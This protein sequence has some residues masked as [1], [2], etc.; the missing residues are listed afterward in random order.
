MGNRRNTAFKQMQRAARPPARAPEDHDQEALPEDQ[1]GKALPVI[2]D[3]TSVC[4]ALGI[5]RRIL[6][7]A[8]TK[9]A[10]GRDW[11]YIG[12]HAGM[13]LDWCE[14]MAMQRQLKPIAMYERLNQIGPGD[15]IFSCTLRNTY[16]NKRRVAVE[17]PNGLIELATVP[18]STGMRLGEIFD[19]R[20]DPDGR[21]VWEAKL[22][23]VKY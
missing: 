20:Q 5:R 6:A 10:R 8:R 1:S 4:Q 22:N 18:D 2:Y 9:A 13:T 23:A 3:D 15:G 11:D 7:E 12:G 14:R 21:L 17:L 19:C 16:P